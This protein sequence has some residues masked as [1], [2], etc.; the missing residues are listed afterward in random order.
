MGIKQQNSDGLNEKKSHQGK[1][2]SSGKHLEQDFDE[3]KFDGKDQEDVEQNAG[4]QGE[5]SGESFDKYPE[6][7]VKKH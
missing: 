3:K 2:N 4:E 5:T 6:K 7:N 1:M